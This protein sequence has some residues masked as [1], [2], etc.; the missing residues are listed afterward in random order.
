MHSYIQSGRRRGC[1]M[2]KSSFTCL[3]SKWKWK[4]T[5]FKAWICECT[6]FTLKGTPK[7][8]KPLD[9]RSWIRLG[10]PCK[11][12]CLELFINWPGLLINQPELFINCPELFINWPELFKP[13]GTILK[14][15]GTILKLGHTLVQTISNIART[16]DMADCIYNIASCA[17]QI[18]NMYF[19]GFV[20]VCKIELCCI[21]MTGTSYWTN[22][23]LLGPWFNHLTFRHSAL[24]NHLFLQ[25]TEYQPRC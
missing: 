6:G 21:T 16:Y 3:F 18:Q 15:A 4:P 2:W 23:Q 10:S 7:Q 12:S 8:H 1:T 14:L 9:C 5:R 25:Y 20:G 22:A 11:G 17:P 19:V 24:C 13:A